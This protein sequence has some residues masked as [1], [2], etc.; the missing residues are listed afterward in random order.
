MV[1]ARGIFVKNY[2]DQSQEFALCAV[3]LAY[4]VFLLRDAK[5]ILPALL[6]APSR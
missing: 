4:P 5:I 2:I 1:A 3:A 6:L